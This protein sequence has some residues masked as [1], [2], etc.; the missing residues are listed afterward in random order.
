[1]SDI[2][3]LV[4]RLVEHGLSISEASS[5]IAEA[6]AAGAATAAYRRSPGALRTEKWRG[7]QR[8]KASQ[9]VTCDAEKS[10]S[11]SVTKRHKASQSVTCDNAPLSN[12]NIDLRK[13]ERRGSRIPDDWKPDREL[14]K[15]LGWSETQIDTEAAN[16]RDYWTAKPGSGGCKLD[17]PATWR[18]WVRNSRTKPAGISSTAMPAF[19]T[20]VD[21]DWKNVISFYKKSGIWSK[22]AGP[23]PD[24]PACKAPPELLREFGL[25]KLGHDDGTN[26]AQRTLRSV[27]SA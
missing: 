6:V 20:P 8:H 19:S 3:A 21:I 11:E 26:E 18:Q 23:D 5:I 27:Q 7:K 15:Q 16:F 4:E 14:A 22:W 9:S 2:G 10:E 12:T 24:S 1:M 13:R 17:W 25:L